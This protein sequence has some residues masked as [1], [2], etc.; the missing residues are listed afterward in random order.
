M[1]VVILINFCHLLH[2]KLSFLKTSCA[3]N[4]ESLVK[5]WYFRLKLYKKIEKRNDDIHNNL[6]IKSNK[7]VGTKLNYMF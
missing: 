1:N 2:R 5:W 3:V 7:S 4:D 6:M